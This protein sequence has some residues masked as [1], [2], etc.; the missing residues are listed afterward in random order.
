[1]RVI[2]ILIGLIVVTAWF[3]VELRKSHRDL[4]HLLLGIS[5]LLTILAI[6]AFFG[7]H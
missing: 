1:M 3:G 6:A 4:A 5:G 7:I 2:Y